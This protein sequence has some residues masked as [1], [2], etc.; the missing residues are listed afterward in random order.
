MNSLLYDTIPVLL[1]VIKEI[2]CVLTYPMSPEAKQQ[3][4]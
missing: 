3:I 4:S 1:M 2:D